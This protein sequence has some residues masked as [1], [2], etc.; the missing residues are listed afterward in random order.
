MT[1][2]QLAQIQRKTAAE[3]LACTKNAPEQT[4]LIVLETHL[5]AEWWRGYRAASPPII[6]NHQKDEQSRA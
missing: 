1:E 2:E 6:S 3:L 4:A 5:N